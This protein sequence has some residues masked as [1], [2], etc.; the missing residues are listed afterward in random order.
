MYV[1]TKKGNVKNTKTGEKFKAVPGYGCS[2]CV[3]DSS[4]LRDGC[5]PETLCTLIEREFMSYTYP[6]EVIFVRKEKKHA[7]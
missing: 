2:L 5:L 6:G 7:E 4:E 3:F 1:M